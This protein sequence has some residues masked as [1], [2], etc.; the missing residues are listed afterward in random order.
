MITSMGDDYHI[1]MSGKLYAEGNCGIACINSRTRI[2]NGCALSGRLKRLIEKNLFN[3]T[4]AE[5]Y[6]KIYAICIYYL[7]KDKVN[8]IENL[9]ICND[10]KFIYVKLYLEELFGVEPIPKII[11]ITEFQKKLGRKVKSLAD[12]AADSYRKRAL[13]R[14]KWN[15][16]I[17]L[18][19]VEIDYE[20]I[21]RKW[22][23][24]EKL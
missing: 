5:D 24:S 6:A 9:I 19:V 7:I 8:E 17:P 16:G 12:N 14:N 21:N 18:D 11:S 3:T 23:L 13:K 15:I 20:R 1:D 2:H 22:N 10:E 4:T